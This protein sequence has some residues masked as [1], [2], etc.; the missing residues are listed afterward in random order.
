MKPIISITSVLVPLLVS[1][2]VNSESLPALDS[3]D[4]H[5]NKN[6]IHLAEFNVVSSPASEFS[7]CL[8]IKEKIVRGLKIDPE[9]GFVIVDNN[10][11]KIHQYCHPDGSVILGCSTTVVGIAI[12][13]SSNYSSTSGKCIH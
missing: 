8:L 1:L 10:N 13:E 3:D 6:N 9:D 12:Q 5:E 7:K 11:L 2:N 4:K